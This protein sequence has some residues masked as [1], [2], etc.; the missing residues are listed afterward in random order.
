M[1]SSTRP[2]LLLVVHAL[3]GGSIHFAHLLRDHV[4]PWANVVFAW[5]VGNRSL[6]IS[7]RDPERAEQ[8]FD[9]ASGLEAPVAA[10]RALDVQRADLLCTIGLDAHLDELLDRLAV[11]YDVSILAYEL[12]APNAH[13]MDADGRFIGERAVASMAEAITP[14]AV[15]PVLRKAERRIACSRDLAWRAA[16]F[17]PGYPILVA[18]PPEKDKPHAVA[19]TLPSLRAGEPLR[20]LVLGRLAPHKGLAT[21]REVARI[22]DA[23][24]S[25][26]EIMCLGEAQV[27]P[28]DLPASACVRILGRYDVGALRDIVR[29]LDPHLAWLPFVVPETHSFVLSEVMSL[30]LPLLATGIGA[31]P[32]RVEGRPATWLVP[33]DDASPAAF[34][35]W[36]EHLH[37]ERLTTPAVWMPTGHLPPLVPGFYEREYL[38]PLC[39]PEPARLTVAATRPAARRPS[40]PAWSAW[41]ELARARRPARTAPAVDVIVPVYRGHDDT[42]ATLHSVLASRNATPYELVVIDDA[43][44]EPDLVRALDAIA[45]RGLIDLVHNERNQGFVRSANAGMARH[46]DR[47]VILLNA[48][49]IVYG[50]WIDRLCAQRSGKSKIGTIT[51]WSNNASLLSYPTTFAN[52]DFDLEIDFAEFDRLVAHELAGETYDLPTG[53]G[54]CFHIGRDCLDDIG[55]FDADAFGRGYGEENDFCLRAA[56]RGWRN[57][58]ACDVFV[59][60]TGEVSFQADAAQARRP[61]AA[62]LLALHPGYMELVAAFMRADP[63]RPLRQRLDLARLERWGAGKLVLQCGEDGEAQLMGTGPPSGTRERRVVRLCPSADEPTRLEIRPPADLVLPNLPRLATEDVAAATRTLASLGVAGVRIGS[64]REFSAE[65]AAFLRAVAEALRG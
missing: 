25:P 50:D 51:P 18:R 7:T 10:L 4:A 52:N 1:S 65:Q 29:Q 59:R 42:L 62:A 9:L 37:R 20:I 40:A 61:A 60:H 11:P 17:L 56:A 57:I 14:D 58:A 32:E 36:F 48:D 34:V 5:G 6:H 55:A 22:A 2:T 24:N 12:L 21:I 64:M 16:R 54:F 26:V 45:A 49:T 33:F 46:P 23:R 41:N 19:P 27:P 63:L 44:P 53:V 43:S 35:Q 47:D 28:S 13:L 8:S 30:G 3:G 31:V 15:R 38:A 39:G